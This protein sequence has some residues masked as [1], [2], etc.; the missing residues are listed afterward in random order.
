M[1]AV[2]ARLRPFNAYRYIRFTGV[3]SSKISAPA[4]K[5]AM[6]AVF[7]ATVSMALLFPRIRRIGRICFL[8]TIF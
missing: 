4:G 7:P 1:T 2:Y 8:K 3:P 6:T 5:T